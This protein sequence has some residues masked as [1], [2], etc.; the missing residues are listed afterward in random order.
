MVKRDYFSMLNDEEKLQYK[1]K[2]C[3]LCPFHEC[4]LI[5]EY[6]QFRVNHAQDHKPQFLVTTDDGTCIGTATILD[7][8]IEEQDDEPVAESGFVDVHPHSFDEDILS[9]D[10]SELE[11]GCMMSCRHVT[12][13]ECGRKNVSEG[14]GDHYKI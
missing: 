14:I 8:R 5:G 10:R 9:Y 11:D 4:E 7:I 12:Q 1:F 6:K 2:F 3:E 13:V